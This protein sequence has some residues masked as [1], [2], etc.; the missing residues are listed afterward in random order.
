MTSRAV[1]PSSYDGETET[2]DGGWYLGKE[3][4]EFGENQLVLFGFGLHISNLARDVL[5][6]RL[7][8]GVLLL[9]LCQRE[10]D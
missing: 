3:G 8:V 10:K 5:E 2:E 9:Q 7:V 4:M 6:V 1:I